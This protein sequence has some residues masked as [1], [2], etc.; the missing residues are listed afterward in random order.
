[1]MPLRVVKKCFLWEGTAPRRCSGQ[2]PFAENA[3]ILIGIAFRNG[4][5][6]IYTPSHDSMRNSCVRLLE[7]ALTI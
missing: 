6:L 5:G 2:A 1:M 7:A 4:A 3:E